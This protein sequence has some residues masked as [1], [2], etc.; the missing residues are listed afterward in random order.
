MK[1]QIEVHIDWMDDEGNVDDTIKNAVVRRIVQETKSTVSKKAVETAEKKAEEI[2]EKAV[3]EEVRR[4]LK[5]KVTTTD[6]FGDVIRKD[7]SVRTIIKDQFAEA[8]HCKVDRNGKASNGYGAD[9]T[10]LEWLLQKQV[11]R[12]V[13]AETKRLDSKVAEQVK[14]TINENLKES[15][16]DSVKKILNL[17]KILKEGR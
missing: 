8:L 2:I 1:M 15:M 4:F 11:S 12:H 9:Q 5:G 13:E 16:A 6:R 17:D 3:T 10:R 7:I 14:A